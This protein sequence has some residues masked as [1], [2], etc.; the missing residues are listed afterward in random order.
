MKNSVKVKLKIEVLLDT[1]GRKESYTRE[2][3]LIAP[4]IVGDS[5]DLLQPGTFDVAVEK[6]LENMEAINEEYFE[7]HS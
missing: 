3:V 5:A 2:S 1:P 7:S 6:I 4:K